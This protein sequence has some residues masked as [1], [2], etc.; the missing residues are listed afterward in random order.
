MKTGNAT[1]VSDF[2]I[3]DRVFADGC[4]DLS[5]TVTAITWRSTHALVECSWVS[6]QAYSAWIEPFRLT[7]KDSR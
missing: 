7:R 4:D 2:A 1:Y 6:G 5:M 3:G